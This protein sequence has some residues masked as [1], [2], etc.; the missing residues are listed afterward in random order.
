[1]LVESRKLDALG[2]GQNFIVLPTNNWE[3]GMYYIEL[4]TED[5]RYCEK[6]LVR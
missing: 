1:M 4:V 3:L 2:A 6:L 5:Q